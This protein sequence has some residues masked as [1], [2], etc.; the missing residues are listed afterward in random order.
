MKTS[1]AILKRDLFVLLK[2][3]IALLVVGA[4]LIL[5]GLYAWYCILA[6]WDPYSNTGSMPIAVVNED[7]GAYNSLAGT[8]NVGKQVT[9]K[10]KDNDKIDW[11]IYDSKEEAL[12]DT[13][14][15]V[16]YAAIVLPE[17]LS[18]DLVGIF[19]GSDKEPTIYYYPNE[20]YS[21]VATK[22]CD[23]ASK[24]LIQQINQGF[25]STVNSKILESVQDVS[26]KV[27]DR[28]AQMNQ[29]AIAEVHAIQ[30][31]LEKVIVSLDDASSAINGWR[32]AATG[33][34][35]ALAAASEQLPVISSSLA[36]GSAELDAF[37]TATGDFEGDL[38][39][40]ILRSA[41]TVSTI[42]A[43]AINTLTQ[44]TQDLQTVQTRLEALEAVA[45]GNPDLEYLVAKMQLIVEI[46]QAVLNGVENRAGEI[47]TT[48]QGMTDAV[49]RATTRISG[50]VMPK[51]SSGTYEL[52][53]SFSKLS[54]AVGQ[55]EP[56]LV[57]L[58]NVL[59]QTDA[60]LAD[61]EQAIADAK[62]LLA[63]ISTNLKGTV[64]DIGAIGGALKVERLQQ[65]LNIDPENMSTFVSS[66]V[67]MVTEK[68]YPVSNYGTAVAP[69]YTNLALWI[70]CFIL[71]SLIKVEVTGFSQATARQRYFGRWMLFI[72]LSLLQSQAICGVDILLGIDCGNPVAFMV[73]GA[74]CSFAYMNLIFALVKTFRNIGKTLCIFLLIMQVPGS[75]GMYPIEM[76]P[77]FF[78]SIHPALPFTYGIDAMREALSGMYGMKYFSDLLVILLIVPGSLIIGLLLR[79]AMT[80]LLL[81]FD[82]EMNKVGFL[83]SEEY[84]EGMESNRIRNL[85][86]ALAAN[87]D[88]TD[89]IEERAWRFNRTYPRLRKAGLIATFA[90]PLAFL[91]LMLPLNLGLNLSTDIKLGALV[92]MLLLLLTVMVTLIILEYM[93]RSITSEMEVLGASL[94]EEGENDDIPAL[95]DGAHEVYV[96][97]PEPEV[98][99]MVPATAAI[100]SREP[101]GGP[102][103]DI[104][105]TDMRL[106]FKSAIG[107]AVIMLLVI[108]P[109]MY[110]WFNIAGS[111]DP[112]SATGNLKVAVA[113]EDDGYKGELIPITIN[114]GDTVVSQLRG[115]TNF[116]W[117]FVSK[118]EAVSGVQSGKYY[119]AIEI[120]GSF[121]ANMMTYLIED[122]DYPDV[123]YY[124]NEKQNPIAPLITQKG[125]DAIQENIRVSFTKRIDAV[126]L[127]VAYDVLDYVKSPN[128]SNYV[129]KM[130][131]HLDDAILDTKNAAKETRQIATLSGTASNIVDTTGVTIDGLKD[132][133]E[134]AKLAVNDA[135]SGISNATSA[136][137]EAAAVV[138]DMLNGRS[139]DIDK[140]MSIND[141]ALG[142]L[143]SGAEL[144]P[145]RIDSLIADVQAARETATTD[146]QRAQCDALINALQDT[147][148]YADAV[149]GKV[150]NA[151]VQNDDMI[152]RAAADIEEARAFFN[153]TVTPSM[154]NLRSTF[155]TT[156]SSTSRVVSG[157]EDAI[158]GIGESTGGLSNQLDTLSNG[159]QKAGDKLE[160]AATN[161]ESTKQ[162][163]SDALKSGKMQDIEKTILGGDP[164]LMSTSLSAPIQQK[165]E[166]IYA[167]G[168]FGS[169]MAPF[170]TVLS[171]W[172]GALVMI[173]T[174]RVHVVEERME[175]L[176]RRY[177]KVR[178]RHEFFG[179][180]GIFGFV[181]LLQGT[182]VLLGDLMFLHIQCEH[183]IAF[184]LL[185]LFIGQMFCLI[186]YTITE[187]FGDVGK[188][189][190]VILLIMQVAASGGTFPVEMLHP[191][192]SNIVPFLPFYHAMTMLQECVAGIFLPAVLVSVAALLAMVGGLL[193]LGLP[194]RRPFRFINNFLEGQLEK[195]GYM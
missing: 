80:N 57:S 170:Y 188:A 41:T 169:S 187:L 26:D 53:T 130:S 10:L 105:T 32:N 44:A 18:K 90:L 96:P 68:V 124:T 95:T 27:E 31:D 7:R 60:A 22:V 58:D 66:P 67:K 144:V 9:D 106:G 70:G 51:L 114:V 47:N 5:P 16:V 62:L 137:D 101:T 129:A 84:Q 20:K 147:K 79:P 162:R 35:S 29:S 152:Q 97:E 94:L 193:L 182:I 171:L 177:I 131:K 63:D 48:V 190:C 115:N 75:S 83:A 195:T 92:A 172:V 30:A 134:S 43:D 145:S 103:R 42:S 161:I 133:S 82:E 113:N 160:N 132:A 13:R 192:L 123:V 118:E 65:L 141:T 21:A 110:A 93:H 19:E 122:S 6:N 54:G 127:S 126:A 11:K 100:G 112:Y 39:S 98:L 72:I 38:S 138:R 76:M 34:R 116:D 156:I 74:F 168:N 81:M 52:A 69:F 155:S 2:N 117:V 157:L 173:S 167:V 148:R 102:T 140:I 121:S 71:A 136:L 86:R 64:T 87:R 164:E 135:K 179:R 186:V 61:A 25:S 23:S 175:E 194:L 40:S 46:C 158:N 185:G 91:V 99:S 151:R 189:L 166:A 45:G 88:Y 139:I 56:Q 15:G 149:P 146:E 150:E 125:A 33:A 108:T 184:F 163:V 119:A 109:A 36:Q 59:V 181:G 128:V 104:F 77:G 180:Y 183:P 37:R 17:D 174:M 165:R 73:A 191:Y 176:R 143:E 24:T 50:E 12:Q 78:Q 120:P 14:D 159:L 55:F 153:N 28:A 154:N 3:P 8:V 178:P 111:W 1:L 85:V 4:L 49:S 142:L 89:D 107:V